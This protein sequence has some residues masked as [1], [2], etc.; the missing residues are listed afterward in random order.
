[1]QAK[2]TSSSD[3]LSNGLLLKISD[4]SRMLNV[5]SSTLRQWENAGLTRPTRT[6]TGYRTYSQEEVERLKYIK[7]LR[8]DKNL[9][10]D[11]VRHLLESKSDGPP[12]PDE[13][14]ASPARDTASIGRQLRRLRRGQ[15]MTLASA[16]SGIGLSVSFLSS[17]ERG[18]VHA[19]I[20]TLQRLAVFYK[21]SVL[22]FFGQSR[23]SGKL[24]R[25]HQRK[26][27]S[28]EPGIHIELLAFGNAMMEP[29]LFRLAPGV[30][31]GGSYHHEGEEFIYMISG[32]CDIW[33]DEVE[34]YQLQQGDSLFFAS[35]QTH[36]WSN[37][38]GEQT[39]VLLWINT[40][41]A[42]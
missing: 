8:T 26:E 21:T 37:P 38:S 24:V 1:M 9:N 10:V 12:K 22:S 28:T 16:A 33:L 20:A 15:K 7:H 31:S 42:F 18:Q 35:S 2:N 34:H 17:L 11:A 30:S 41:P 40:P 25:P 36:R 23:K 3:K 19:S 29:H 13:N 27:L 39:A 14:A 4:V 6:S 32:A 5:S